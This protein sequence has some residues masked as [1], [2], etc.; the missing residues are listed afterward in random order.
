M[1]K[2]YREELWAWLEQTGGMQIP[3]KRILERRGDHGYK[4]LN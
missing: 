4:G 1:I 3:L 2:E